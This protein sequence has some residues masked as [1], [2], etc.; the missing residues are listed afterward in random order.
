[1]LPC[2]CVCKSVALLNIYCVFNVAYI[3]VLEVNILVALICIPS[4]KAA[5]HADFC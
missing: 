3:I 4:V 2:G 5:T 1:M